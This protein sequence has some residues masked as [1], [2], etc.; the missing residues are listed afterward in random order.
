MGFS[1]FEWIVEITWKASILIWDW[2]EG[3][4]RARWLI[5]KKTLKEK[6]ILQMKIQEKANFEDF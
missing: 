1:G 2:V 6:S 3:N 4:L 5:N